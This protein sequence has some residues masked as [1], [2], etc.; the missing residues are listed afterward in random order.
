MRVLRG[1][2]RAYNPATGK[3]S[4]QLPGSTQVFAGDVPVASGL[5]RSDLVDGAACTVVAF[6]DFNP[7]NAMV[8]AVEGLPLGTRAHVRYGSGNTA[9]PSAV[10][11]A[12]QFDTVM[13][14]DAGFFNPA[15]PARLT[16]PAGLRGTFEISASVSFQA[17]GTGGRQCHIR[18]NGATW[19]NSAVQLN[20]TA[21]GPTRFALSAEWPM[22]G[23]DYAEVFV[24]QDSGVVLNVEDFPY[25]SPEFRIRKVG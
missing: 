14:D 15:Q 21:S 19:I 7:V 5:A 10:N 8:V 16:V 4:V 3:A 17:N 18:V 24:R 23:G 25:I 22:A 20:A 12:L 9:I 6:D 11:T 13:A 1:I 2:I